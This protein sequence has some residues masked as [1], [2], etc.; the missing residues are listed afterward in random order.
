[1]ARARAI[2]ERD[3]SLFGSVPNLAES[4]VC[5]LCL[6]PVNPGY[7]RCFGCHRLTTSTTAVPDELLTRVVPM[8]TAISPS[9]WYTRLATYK[10]FRADYQPTLAALAHTFLRSNGAAIQ[11]LLGGRADCITIVPSKRGISYEEQPFRRV[12]SL[13]SS[14]EEKLVHG[15]NYRPDANYERQ[16]YDPAWFEK[17]RSKIAGRRVL[18]LEDTWA[19]GATCLSAA[20]ALLG[21]GAR[22][23]V[24]LPIARII[25]ETFWSEHTPEYLDAA[26]APY[27]PTA[28]PR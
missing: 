17:G 21:Y 3:R 18:L 8:T 9:P 1:M 20:G 27:D 23:V 7:S 13:V 14:I 22:S 4:F 24:A 5:D 2:F 11:E 25:T 12:L 28:W 19:S 6:G 16:R 15:L 10:T 26:R